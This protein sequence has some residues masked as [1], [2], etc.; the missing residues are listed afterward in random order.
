MDCYPG[1]TAAGGRTGPR[2]DPAG[3]TGGHEPGFHTKGITMKLPDTTP[4]ENIGEIAWIKDLNGRYV[5]VN[6]A[7]ATEFRVAR[8]DVVGKTDFYIFPVQLA[9]RLMVNDFEVLRAGRPLR[10]EDCISRNET[11]KWVEALKSPIIDASGE[12]L[13]TLTVMRDLTARRRDQ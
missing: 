11:R 8:A 5:A 6:Q 10:M 9:G 3:R 7:F 2:P 13:G 4:L 12:I 1:A